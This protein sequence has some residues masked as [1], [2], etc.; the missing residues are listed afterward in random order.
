M[1]APVR[2]I[3]PNVEM[4]TETKSELPKST[5]NATLSDIKSSSSR[6]ARMIKCLEPNFHNGN[7]IMALPRSDTGSKS[8]TTPEM[9]IECY[10]RN[11]CSSNLIESFQVSTAKYTSS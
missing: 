3:D 10:K 6:E 4:Q 1:K 7:I 11:V 2:K 5:E 8:Y 9:W